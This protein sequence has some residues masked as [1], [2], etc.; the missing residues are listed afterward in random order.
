[1]HAAIYLFVKTNELRHFIWR[2]WWCVLWK[3]TTCEN[4]FHCFNS[5]DRLLGD[6]KLFLFCPRKIK[7]SPISVRSSSPIVF[8][9]LYAFSP[10][11]KEKRSVF[12]FQS[13][14]F[15]LIFPQQTVSARF[16]ETTFKKQFIW[17][18]GRRNWKKTERRDQHGD[19]VQAQIKGSKKPQDSRKDWKIELNNA[20]DKQFQKCLQ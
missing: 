15:Q 18:L 13:F 16:E 11:D 19:N 4:T 3:N 1:M 17:R 7:E 2:G 8:L 6:S 12:I 9:I 10:Q 20:R 5:K 14:F